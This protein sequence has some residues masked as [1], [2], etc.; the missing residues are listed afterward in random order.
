MCHA[1]TYLLQFMQLSGSSLTLA[2]AG[3]ICISTIISVGVHEFGHAVAAAGSVSL[4]YT[5]FY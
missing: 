4:L 1:C 3:Y 2:D 5:L